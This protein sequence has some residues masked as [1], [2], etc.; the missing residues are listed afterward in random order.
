VAIAQFLRLCCVDGSGSWNN[1][2]GKAQELQEVSHVCQRREIGAFF[3]MFIGWFAA[4]SQLWSVGDGGYMELL[5]L[6]VF[7][8]ALLLVAQ[9]ALGRKYFWAVAFA[10]IAVLFNPLAPLTLSRTTFLVLDAVCIWFFILSL[11]WSWREPKNNP[12]AWR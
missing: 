11:T 1:N 12:I 2:V 7:S 10:A 9:T 4:K 8:A 5:V 6:A 3:L